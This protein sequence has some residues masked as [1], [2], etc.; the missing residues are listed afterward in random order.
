MLRFLP[1][2]LKTLWRHRT[3]TLLTVSGTAVALVVFSFVTAVQEGLARLLSDRQHE[4][5]LIVF[6]ANRFCPSTSKLPEDY[7]RRIERVPGV[8]SAV[9]IK[10]Y[11]NNCRASL[12]VVVFNGLPAEKLRQVRELELIEGDWTTFEKQ[13]DAA[14][15]GQGVAQRRQLKVGQK[16]SIGMLT[17]TVTGIFR[18]PDQSTENM[19]FTHLDFLQR[20]RGLNSVGTV[21]QLEVQL[22]EQADPQATSQAIDKLF[23]SGPTATN[24]RTKGVFQASAVGDLVELV[25]FARYLGIACVG[26]VLGLVATTTVMGVQDRIKEHAVLQTMGFTGWHIFGFVIA[27]SILVSLA[28]GT[29]G[30][31]AALAILATSNFALGTEGILITFLPSFTLALS[32]LAAA[33]AVGLMAGFIPA[34]QAARAEIVPAL[35]FG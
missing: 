33:L 16:F 28:G 27:E 5:T 17:V 23:R 21:T 14:V 8:T 7:S 30:V 26:L 6:Q 15:V 32:G 11:M 4:R 35:R 1:Y 18:S 13:P 22:N 10:V 12:D 31:G 3:R 25:G 19:I 34:V 29:I 24:T 9:P 20:T 2:I